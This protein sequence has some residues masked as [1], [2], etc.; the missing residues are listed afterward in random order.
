MDG[1]LGEIYCTAMAASP[2]RDI[3]AALKQLETLKDQHGT[4]IA[5]HL[6]KFDYLIGRLSRFGRTV[7]E[8]ELIRRLKDSITED[9][10]KAGKTLINQHNLP[11]QQP[12]L[13]WE[14]RN[15]VLQ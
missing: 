13:Y 14:Q 7:P 4:N 9:T 15:M 3:D 12:F 1:P 5:I 2:H 8:D 11:G 10:Y 6:N